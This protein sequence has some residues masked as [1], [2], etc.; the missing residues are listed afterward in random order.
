MTTEAATVKVVVRENCS[1]SQ[2]IDIW[3]LALD[4]T[5]KKIQTVQVS[6]EWSSNG[7]DI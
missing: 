3:S 2:E 6:I 4:I 1:C 5:K 7:P